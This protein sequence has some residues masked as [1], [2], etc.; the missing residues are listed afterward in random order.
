MKFLW[1]DTWHLRHWLHCWQLRTTLLTITLWP[2]NKECWWQHSQFLRCFERMVSLPLCIFLAA[3][4]V[5][6]EFSR[7]R[8]T[9]S[10]IFSFSD[11]LKPGRVVVCFKECT[12]YPICSLFVSLW[13]PTDQPI[14][15]FSIYANIWR[16]LRSWIQFSAEALPKIWCLTGSTLLGGG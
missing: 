8:L 4:F 14:E 12:G 11:T 1:P 10:T 7:S 6:N 2:L 3:T 9:Q 5:E 15:I 13:A 16:T